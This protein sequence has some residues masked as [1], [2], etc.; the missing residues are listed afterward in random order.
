MADSGDLMNGALI[1]GDDGVDQPS[2]VFLR[3]SASC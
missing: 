1:S 3:T 2:L